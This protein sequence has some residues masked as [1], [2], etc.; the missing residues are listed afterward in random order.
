GGAA[1]APSRQVVMKLAIAMI[2]LIAILALYRLKPGRVAA[3]FTD[4]KGKP[5]V[6]VRL[7]GGLARL[8]VAMTSLLGRQRALA[9]SLGWHLFAW[10]SQVGETWMVL[11]LV[12]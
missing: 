6:L 10:I 3:R 8:Q 12:G 7:S 9:Q 11:A 1:A 2:P 5:G 4:A